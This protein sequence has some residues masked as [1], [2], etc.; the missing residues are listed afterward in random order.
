MIK[1]NK[2]ETIDDIAFSLYEKTHFKL[3]Q[4]NIG[5]S[6]SKTFFIIDNYNYEYY[7]KAEKI[8]RKNKLKKIKYGESKN[9]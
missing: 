1:K 2:N 5:R 8:L 6:L 4:G 7:K 9:N 3:I